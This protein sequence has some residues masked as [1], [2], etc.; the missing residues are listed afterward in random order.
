MFRKTFTF[1]LLILFSLIFVN[2]MFSQQTG[3]GYGMY[4]ERLKQELN[5]TPEQVVK[6][7]KILDSAQKQAEIDREKYQGNREA[8]MKATRERWEKIDKEIEAV[9]TK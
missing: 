1:A 2:F 9:L 4:L 8:M 5:L 7:Q 3:R 6:I